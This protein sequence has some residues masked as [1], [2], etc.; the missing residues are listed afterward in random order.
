MKPLAQQLIAPSPEELE[1]RREPL[2]MITQAIQEMQAPEHTNNIY[3]NYA[4]D[5]TC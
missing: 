4:F 3:Q 2:Y 1:L 5:V